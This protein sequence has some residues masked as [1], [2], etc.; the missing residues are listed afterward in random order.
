[1]ATIGNL[2]NA[3]QRGDT[4]DPSAFSVIADILYKRGEEQ[5][6]EQLKQQRIQ[7]S[8]QMLQSIAAKNMYPNSSKGIDKAGAI[9][10]NGDAY[11]TTTF[12]PKLSLDKNGYPDISFDSINPNEDL[13]Q[14]QRNAADIGIDPTGQSRWT[15]IKTIAQKKADQMR[16]DAVIPDGMEVFGYDAQGRRILRKEKPISA[17]EQKAQMDLQDRNRANQA[18]AEM[19]KQSAQDTLNTVAEVEKG[20]NNFGTL[21]DVPSIPGTSRVNWESN[22]SKLMSGQV[23]DVINKMKEASKNGATGFG[24]LSEKEL[25]VLSNAATALKR[26][27]PPQEA[28]KY[29][30]QIKAS[31]QKVLINSPEQ[32][33]QSQDVNANI[34]AARAAGYSDAEIQQYLQ[35]R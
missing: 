9:A 22:V 16:Q 19:V 26:S 6:Q 32:P 17:Q 30:N 7:N 11:G 8:M 15:L 33:G 14:L 20:I 18:H 2:I 5:R 34:E 24:A 12:K 25:A 13:P 3:G 29:L 27:L 21:G 35:G 31:S 1:M 28:Q 4:N 10:E 23:L